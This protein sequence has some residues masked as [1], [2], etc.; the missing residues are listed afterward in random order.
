MSVAAVVALLDEL[1]AGDIAHPGGDLRSHLIRTHDTLRGW[2]APDD[3]CLAGLIHAAYGTDA[4]PLALLPLGERP[5]LRLLVGEAAEAIVYRY[6]SCSRQVSYARLDEVPWPMTDRFT[7]EVVLLDRDE[8]SAF[9]VLTIANERD[10][11][12]AGGVDTAGAAAIE[13]LVRALRPYLQVAIPEVPD[14]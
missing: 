14:E 7:G 6:C 13:D 2:S 12:Q 8:A 10:I 1:G 3:V 5:R 9:A 4:F 11:V